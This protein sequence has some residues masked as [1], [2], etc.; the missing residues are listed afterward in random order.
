[1]HSGSATT[2]ESGAALVLCSGI[3]YTLAVP[4]YDLSSL[5]WFALAPFFLAIRNRRSAAAFLYGL[6]FGVV[7]CAGIAHWFCSAIASFFVIPFPLDLVFTLLAYASFAGFYSGGAGAASSMFM[8]RGGGLRWL[9]VPSAW[10]AAEFARASF[11]PGSSWELLGH[12]QYGNLRVIQITDITGVYGVSFLMALAGYI[13]AEFFASAINKP[14]CSLRPLL[15]PAAGLAAAIAVVLVYGELRIEAYR[16]PPANTKP[17][18]IALVRADVAADSRW[19]RA[20]YASNL[21]SYIGLTRRALFH[22]RSDLIVWPEFA[23]GFYL[24]SELALRAQV[25]NLAR[26]TESALLL[27]APRTEDDGREARF[28]N[29]VYL[30]AAD[31]Q[32]KGSYDK[33]HLLP[34]AEYRSA[35]FPAITTSTTEHPR[36]FSAGRTATVFSLPKARFGVMICYESTYAG[37]ARSLVMHGA[38]FL[39][40]VSNDVWL[41][42]S[43]PSAALQNFSMAVFRAVENK[44]PLAVSTAHGVSGF[45]DAT[46]WVQQSSAA[47]E[48]VLLGEVAPCSDVTIYARCGDWFAWL[49]VALT[50]AAALRPS[51]SGR[52]R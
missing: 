13:E 36:R 16:T 24:D 21:M 29:S 14:G 20:Y 52:A 44:R 18:Q 11:S 19:R 26:R 33:L 43:G 2:A 17:L 31:G 46:G 37:L 7:F 6:L 28:F 38:Q 22:R 50:L 45:I 3:L 51:Q 12:S 5:G 25:A 30:L 49:C 8:R 41:I 27:G 47:A 15:L 9:A 23:V 39:V 34:F 40:N 1:L 35:V 48:G 32:L 10:V 42:K 4:P